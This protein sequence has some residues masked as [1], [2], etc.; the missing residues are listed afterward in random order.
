MPQAAHDAGIAALM[1]EAAARDAM[2]MA[3]LAAVR[4]GH[5]VVLETTCEVLRGPP[6]AALLL[7]HALVV[8][9]LYVLCVVLRPIRISLGPSTT[10]HTGYRSRMAELV[11]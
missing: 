10:W 2:F 5:R 8:W 6:C 3:E 9:R 11:H 1:E 7:P 4:S